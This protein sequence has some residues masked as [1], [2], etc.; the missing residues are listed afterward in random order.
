MGPGGTS[1]DRLYGSPASGGDM[2]LIN[3]DFTD[4]QGK[5]HKRA[6]SKKGLDGSRFRSYCYVTDDN[7]WFD[8]SGMPINKPDDLLKESNSEPKTEL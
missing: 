4:Y 6:L 7:R 3:K 5:I 2:R 1:I 8:R